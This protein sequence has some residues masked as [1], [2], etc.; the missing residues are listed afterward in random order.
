MKKFFLITVSV[1]LVGC[2]KP[3]PSMEVLGVSRADGV[4]TVGYDFSR[5]THWM[6]KGQQMNFTGG[7]A[8]AWRVCQGW[9]YAGARAINIMPVSKCADWSV[10]A[11]VCYVGQQKQQ[12]QCTTM[13][14]PQ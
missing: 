3:M 9:G 6:E 14:N 1:I 12:Y 4:V 2:A 13:G 5:E 8:L 11:G 10:V 7:D